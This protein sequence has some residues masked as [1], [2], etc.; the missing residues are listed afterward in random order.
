M[1]KLLAAAGTA[2]DYIFNGTN[3]IVGGG[4][5]ITVRTNRIGR[6][7][8]DFGDFFFTNFCRP[9]FVLTSNKNKLLT[10]V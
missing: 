5:V 6:N 2:V 1:F 4:H 10:N 9:L 3:L 8:C 7:S